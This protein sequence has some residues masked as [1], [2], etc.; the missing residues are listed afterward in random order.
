M[1]QVLWFPHIKVKAPPVETTGSF[2]VL[3]NVFWQT[4]VKSKRPK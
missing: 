3:E 1:A 2:R 4:M